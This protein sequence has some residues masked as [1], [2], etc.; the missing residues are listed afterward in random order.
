[1]MREDY[2]PIFERKNDFNL[3]RELSIFVIQKCTF[4]IKVCLSIYKI[5]NYTR[6]SL[7]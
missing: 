1:M 3:C 4:E 7:I 2:V 6:L 5:L